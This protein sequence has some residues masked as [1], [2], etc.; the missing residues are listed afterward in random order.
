MKIFYKPLSVNEV[1][2]G[3]RF[4]TDAYKVYERDLLFLLPKL[5]LPDPPYHI[6]LKFGL[7]NLAADFDN[8]VKPFVDILQKKYNF[9]DRDIMQATIYKTI[10]PKGKEFIEFN[11]TEFI[12]IPF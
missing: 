9:N 7:S 12:E 4:K 6:F 5:I 3:R 8:P 10:V 1:W 11:L 2:K